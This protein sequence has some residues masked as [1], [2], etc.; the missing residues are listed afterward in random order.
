MNFW[1]LF[2]LD[3][4]PE[5]DYEIIGEWNTLFLDVLIYSSFSIVIEG[6]TSREKST[7]CDLNAELQ[8]DST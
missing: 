8:R 4:R 6:I 3:S 5:R 7:S 1:R 2:N